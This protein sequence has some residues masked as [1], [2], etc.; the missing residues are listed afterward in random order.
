MVQFMTDYELNPINIHPIIANN[1]KNPRP[2]LVIPIKND[3]N[4]NIYLNTYNNDAKQENTLIKINHLS[5]DLEKYLNKF[6][7][8]L[9]LNDI[10]IILVDDHPYTDKNGK[11]YNKLEPSLNRKFGQTYTND[12][13][14]IVVSINLYSTYAMIHEFGHVLDIY[15]N[16]TPH[17]KQNDFKPYLKQYQNI[18]NNYID[19]QKSVGNNW[20][21]KS[22]NYFNKPEE[23]FARIFNQ[24][25]M[26]HNIPN[27]LI[28][29]S[30]FKPQIAD[31][32][33][34]KVYYENKKSINK[35]F[36]DKFPNLSK[37]FDKPIKNL[38]K[39]IDFDI[40]Y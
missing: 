14:D 15:N 34:E 2:N 22:I 1:L 21:E 25:Y 11:Y 10:I 3:K 30:N 40:D 39:S 12:F 9:D 28:N 35:Y 16:D 24:Y 31:K 17:S 6:S 18:L 38:Q 32:I 23:A 27:R 33:S 37:N 26:E 4:M 5:N 7:T 13:N 19:L 8:T 20:S 36:D 29:L